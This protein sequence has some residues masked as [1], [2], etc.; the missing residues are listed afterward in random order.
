MMKHSAR[1]LFGQPLE[2]RPLLYRENRPRMF[3]LLSL[4]AHPEDLPRHVLIRPLGTESR[5]PGEM[6]RLNA[7]SPPIRR[8]ITAPVDTIEEFVAGHAAPLDPIARGSP[9]NA[10]NR[11]RR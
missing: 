3:H 1:F 6:E 9:E 7:K 10:R 4:D 2:Y 5:K 8:H 11:E